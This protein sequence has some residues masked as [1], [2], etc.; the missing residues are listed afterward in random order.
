MGRRGPPKTPTAIK[1]VR[2][3]RRA[4]RE[5]RNEP[6][7]P[8]GAP[9]CP[10][11]LGPVARAAW[12]HWQPILSEMGV[13]TVADRSILELTCQAYAQYRQGSKI[14]E[15][16]GPVVTFET[17][18][19]KGVRANPAVSFTADAWRRTI[20]G[21][22]EL[23]LTP[24]ARARVEA[25]PLLPPGTPPPRPVTPSRIPAAST[26]KGDEFFPGN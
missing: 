25:D 3:T 11:Y 5:P 15:T 17:E 13:L 4:D 10:R 16:D 2:G 7:P 12:K 21:L 24:A 14:I 23:G 9:E 19:G 22:R 26:G 18:K 20:V 8:A 1:D 6:K